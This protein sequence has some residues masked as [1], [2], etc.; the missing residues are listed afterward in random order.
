[1]STAIQRGIS[2]SVLRTPAARLLAGGLVFAAVAGLWLETSKD[3]SA[4][5]PLHLGELSSITLPDSFDVK[6][7]HV[8]PQGTVLL[9]SVNQPYLIVHRGTRRWTLRSSS[10]TRPVAAVL[11]A[12]DTIVEAVDAER[13]AIVRLSLRGSVIGEWPLGLPWTV[14]SAV[15]S[16]SGWVLGGR[17]VAG[18]YRV[19]ALARSGARDRLLT[20]PARRYRGTPVSVSLSEAGGEVFTTLLRQPHGVTRIPA[21]PRRG[22]RPAPVATFAPPMLPDRRDGEPTLWVALAVHPLE[23]GFIRTFADLR[24]D[25]RVLA[26]YGADGSL[27]R[28]SRLDVPMAVL[29]TIPGERLLL[30]ARRTDRLE[31]V[32]YRWRWTGVPPS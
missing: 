28:Q 29:T 12:G 16:E 22:D 1:M 11:N 32:F 14:E 15:H 31:I 18:N 7:A 6:G 30:A 10:I 2:R 27:L 5:S 8:S 17:D 3:G 23:R 24:S 20:I 21:G 25:Q 4:A 13:R 9:W 19:V 26:I